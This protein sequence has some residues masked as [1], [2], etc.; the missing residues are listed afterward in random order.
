MRPEISQYSGPV[1]YPTD[2]TGMNWMEGFLQ[3]A[4]GEVDIVSIHRYPFGEPPATAAT[5]L[6]DPPSW[7][8]MMDNLAAQVRR[9]A[10]RDIPLAVTE[11]N[12]DWTGRIDSES[13]TDSHLNAIWWADVLGRLIRGRAQLVAQFCLGAISQQGIGMFGPIA[14]DAGPKPIYQVYKLYH[15]F[16]TEL[17]HAASDDDTLPIVA[18]RRDARTLTVIVINHAALPRSAPIAIEGAQISGPAEVWSFAE[19]HP[20]EQRGS[21]DLSGPI[22]FEPRSATLLVI[23]L[24]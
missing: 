11:A 21:A 9:A 17:I 15:L 20:V 19:D 3:G 14:Y 23:P 13:G 10:G 2:S 4:G 5:L 22:T 1:G 12:S 8:T 6:A 16:G 18:A 24:Q 7:T